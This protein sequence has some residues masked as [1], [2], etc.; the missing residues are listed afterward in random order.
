[1]TWHPIGMRQK[2]RSTY[3]I[4]LKFKQLLNFLNFEIVKSINSY[5]CSLN[6]LEK[7]I[8]HG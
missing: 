3:S 6:S 7:Q 8:N 5:I 2:H 1:M 4:Y